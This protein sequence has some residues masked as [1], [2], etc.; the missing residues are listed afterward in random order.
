[1]SSGVRKTSDALKANSHLALGRTKQKEG[2]VAMADDGKIT[3]SQIKKKWLDP[4]CT[5]AY[6]GIT[7]VQAG[8]YA[9]T[10]LHVSRKKIHEALSSIPTYSSYLTRPRSGPRRRYFVSHRRQLFEADLCFFK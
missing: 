8:I 10:G 2:K 3:K 7:N 5:Y 9:E 6:S 1:M 4:N